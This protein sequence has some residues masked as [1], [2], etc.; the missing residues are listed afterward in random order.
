MIQ[1]IKMYHRGCFL[2][3]SIVSELHIIRLNIRREYRGTQPP[4]PY[5][6]IN[7]RCEKFQSYAPNIT[8]FIPW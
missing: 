7:E 8:T 1:C 3:C 2:R 6:N 4:Y 5:V